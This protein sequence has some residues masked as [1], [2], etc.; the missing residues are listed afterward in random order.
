M[1]RIEPASAGNDARHAYALIMELVDGPTLADQ[2][3][4][5]PL[6]V[7]DALAVARQIADAL[8]YAHDRGIVHR[9]LKPANVKLSSDRQAKVLDFGLAKAAADPMTDGDVANSPTRTISATE[10]GVILG[11]AA[12]MAPEQARGLPVDRRADIWAFG[13]VLYEMLTGRR[14][15]DG[16]SVTELL[17]A[18]LRDEPDLS[19]LPAG[20]PRRVRD[21]IARC[22]IK[23]PRRRLQAIGEARIALDEA[24][25]NPREEASV[26]P[27]PTV[28]Q[29]TSRW[30]R[31][32]PWAVAGVLAIAAAIRWVPA[33]PDAP[34]RSPLRLSIELSPTASI[35]PDLLGPSVVVSPDGTI[36]AFR[37]VLQKGEKPRI[38]VRRLDQTDAV[39][40]AGTDNAA[41]PFFSPDGQWIAFA[42]EG[43]L[44]K[45]RFTGGDI[46][47]IC[48]VGAQFRGGDWTSDNHI[49]HAQSRTTLLKVP[50][51]GGVPEPVT[52]LDQAKGEITHRFP[53]VLR[54]VNAV[55]FTAHTNSISYDDATIMVQSL[56]SGPP[57]V[58]VHGGYNA[59]YVPSGHVL[60]MHDGTLFAVPFDQKRLEVTG[61][62]VRLV[63]DVWNNVGSAGAQYSVSGSGALV[64]L[65][66]PGVRDDVAMVWVDAAGGEKP[67]RPPGPYLGPRFS[68]DGN[69]LALQVFDH[70]QST[71]GIY[72]IARDTLSRLTN[73]R[74]D[75][76]GVVWTPDGQ[77]ILFTSDRDGSGRAYL[78]LKRVGSA[79]VPVR[80]TDTSRSEREVMGSFHPDGRT[81]LFSGI[82]EALNS[83]WDIM[84]LRIDGDVTK[85]W[86][87]QAPAMVLN[88]PF[89]ESA[90]QLS[91]DGRWLA[92][93]ST[94]TRRR[95]VY[96]VRFPEL[97]GKQQISTAGGNMPVWSRGTQELLFAE[98][99]N[100]LIA[101]PYAPVG[102]D[103][104]PGKPRVWTDQARMEG[105]RDFDVHPDGKRLVVLKTAATP[106]VTVPE[107][108]VLYLN[109]F[110]ELKRI[111]PPGKR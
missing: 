19:A 38:F 28:A 85:D 109:V 21:L 49:I 94:E 86:K 107:K 77:N 75:E 55:L 35:V 89:N 61:T 56:A 46:V 43:K 88:S 65:P 78:Y 6:P 63:T 91:A 67:M 7:D 52:T 93:T 59:R 72:D 60:Y 44:K 82:N 1:E 20:T 34:V 25:A 76:R 64:Y 58:V 90:P 15:Y 10:A 98:S 51:D 47:T 102:A 24:I 27:A 13:V 16:D 99:T 62:A 92:Y 74:A 22:Q 103:F 29:K 18:V 42:A 23:D 45:I 33:A 96:V 5:G 110:D 71:I 87:P 8:E 48:D 66:A 26:V 84:S 36:A 53:Q 37:G 100:R 108:A 70:G 104:R 12:Y 57:K 111:A 105:V 30:S 73:D 68:P 17:A 32:V 80:L 31:A 79:D 4:R 3:A 81:F 41:E 50:A 39:P 40:L 83:E 69:R 14:T 9:D 11:T 95:E 54:D 97:D 106:E 2:I 101:V